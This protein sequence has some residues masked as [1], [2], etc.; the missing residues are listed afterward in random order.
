MEVLC[1]LLYPNGVL[2]FHL[3]AIQL[4]YLVHGFIYIIDN[5][6]LCFSGGALHPP[7]FQ[8]CFNT[9]LNATYGGNR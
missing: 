8:W 4:C 2:M 6:A 1:I 3:N 7:P 5:T 9:L